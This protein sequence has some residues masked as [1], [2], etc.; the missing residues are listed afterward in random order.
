M[1]RKGLKTLKLN[2]KRISNLLD[3]QLKGGVSGSTKLRS[4]RCTLRCE[5]NT[6]PKPSGTLD[7]WK[8]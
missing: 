1:K 3:T 5:G 7:C 2:K 8:K 6:G 4:L